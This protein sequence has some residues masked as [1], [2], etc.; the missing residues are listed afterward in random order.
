MSSR[1]CAAAAGTVLL[2]ALCASAPAAPAQGRGP[3]MKKGAA[4]TP[5]PWRA[6][7]ASARRFAR[8]RTGTVSFAIVGERG[9]LRGLR[10][11]R[12]FHS[13]SVVK[14][15]LMVGYLRRRSVR[16]RRLHGGDRALL[17]PMIQRSDNATATAVY[18]L[19]G[20]T[21]LRRLARAAR[22]RDFHPDAVWGLTRITARD[23][24]LFMFRLRRFI[25][26]RHRRYA[27]RLLSHIVTHQRWGIPP[28][29]PRGWRVYFKG[30]FVPA[31]GGWRINQVARLTR[32][33]HKLGIAVLSHG[34]P[35]LD[36]G[37]KTVQGVTARLLR[38]YNAITDP[39]RAGA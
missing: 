16:N 20:S 33:G 1:L 6:R 12:Q 28:A 36:Y 22:M 9:N 24:A 23:Q 38:R 30:G 39:S 34:N 26:R 37:A 8:H 14:V 7:V 32:R 13:A 29:R 35:T 27:L 25:P 5:Y 11:R 18:G 4:R 2:A 31:A 19:V 21:G 3:A 10:P 17:G 15:M